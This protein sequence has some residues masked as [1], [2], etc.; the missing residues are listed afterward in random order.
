MMKT[1]LAE[2][3]EKSIPPAPSECTGASQ[4]ATECFQML[5]EIGLL[6]V[7]KTLSREN[8]A[9]VFEKVSMLEGPKRDYFTSSYC[10]F[11]RDRIYSFK[12]AD[13]LSF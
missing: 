11:C 13:D 2:A 10:S 3:I 1:S 12:L 4:S 6:P 5:R 8:M 9:T 7:S